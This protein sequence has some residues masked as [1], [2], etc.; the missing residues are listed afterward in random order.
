MKS[1]IKEIIPH[2]EAVLFAAVK[3]MKEEVLSEILETD[4]ETI[5]EGICQLKEALKTNER[6]IILSHSASG[7]ILI[8]SPSSKYYVKKIREKEVPLTPAV[9]ETLSIV[10]FKQ[11]I[12]RSEIEEIRGVSCEH[13]IRILLERGLIEEVGKKEGIGRPILYGTTV[14]FLD[15]MGLSSLSDIKDK[16]SIEYVLP[17]FFSDDDINEEKEDDKASESLF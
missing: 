12:T 14:Q 17:D 3:P 13:G 11:P 16:L 1:K 9:L 6:G 8:T 7:Y 2:I 15:S 10:A 4:L 5:K